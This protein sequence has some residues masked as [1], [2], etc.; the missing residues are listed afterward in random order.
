MKLTGYKKT[1]FRPK[2]NPKFTSVHCIAHL[3]EDVS[4]VLPYLNALFGGAQYFNNPPEL[5]FL[6][7]GKLI[8]IGAREIAINALRDE[9]EAD[10]ILEWLKGEI[11]KAWENRA[12]ITPCYTGKEKPRVIEILKLLP[13]T[14]CKKCGQPTCMVFAVQMA[15]GGRTPDQC[16]ELT[17]EARAK[18]NAYLSRF[19]FD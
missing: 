19:N 13:K 12:S 4:D 7:H 9:E 14:N 10:R 3:N 5:L 2:C 16:P 6:H 11:N 8:K 15:E 1:I 18:L 17:E